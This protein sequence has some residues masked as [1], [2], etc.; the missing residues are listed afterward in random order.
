M[1]QGFLGVLKGAGRSYINATVRPAAGILGIIAHPANGIFRSA[2]KMMKPSTEDV[3]LKP[4]QEL[5][6]RDFARASQE[7]KRK[8][9]AKYKEL[10]KGTAARRTELRKK[11]KEYIAAATLEQKEADARQEREKAEGI[12]KADD[13]QVIK[14]KVK[15]DGQ[16]DAQAEP[17]KPVEE[18]EPPPAESRA[19]EETDPV[20]LAEQR[21]YERALAEMQAKLAAQKEA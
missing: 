6:E 12:Q 18:K 3:L 4:R 1:L 15:P 13:S 11:A 16:G 10:E 7:E 17:E 20:K 21:G 9:L 2:Q 14:V 5:S 8:I 19:Q